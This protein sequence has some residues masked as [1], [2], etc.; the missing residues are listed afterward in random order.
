MGE[1]FRKQ[2]IRIGLGLGLLLLLLGHAAQRYEIPFVNQ[3]D[4]II[5]D[6][7]LRLTMPRTVDDRVVILDIDE[8][9][10]KEEGRWPWS[11]NRLALLLD[12]LFD[13]H[14]IAVLGFDIVFAERDESSGVQVL[15]QLGRTGLHDLPQ[16]RNAVAQ[17]APKLD[18]DRLFAE[19]MKGRRVV[20]GYY[21]SEEQG[22][23]VQVSGQLPPPV[24]PAGS[25]AGRPVAIVRFDGYGANLPELQKSAAGGGHFNPL[26]DPRDGVTRRVPMLGEHRGA[27]YEALSL[28]VV[29]ALLGFPPVVAGIA[30]DSEQY[31][32]L[33]WLDVPTERG[34][35]RIPVDSNACALVPYRGPEGSFR[36]LSASDVL[37]DRVEPGLLKGKIVLMGATAP[38]LLDLRSTPVQA[39]YPGVEIHA[40]LIAGMLDQNIKMQ[41]AYVMG[42]EVVFLLVSG[43]LLV[44][45]M[46][47]LS[48]FVS[49]LVTGSVLAVAV[50]S[51]VALWNYGGL[52]FPLASTVLLIV[53]LFAL[54]MS[55]GY[56]VEAR[57]KRLITG[58]FGRYVSPALVEEMATNPDTVSMEGDS[59]E[60]SV[61][62]SDVRGFTTISERMDPKE[63]SRFMNEFLTPLTEVI[64]QHRG[65]VDKY[66][67]DCIMAFWGAPLPDPNH[68]R[69]AVLAGMAM[70]ATLRGLQARFREMGW[71]EIRAGVGVNSGQVRVGNMGS[72]M[73]IAYTVM[74]DAVNLA[75]RLE[76]ITKQYGVDM[77]VGEHTRS[78]L[79]DF[80]FLELDRVRVKGKDEPVAIYQPLGEAAAAPAQAQEEARLF[81]QALRHY[82]NQDWDQAELALYNL[83]KISPDTELYRIYARRV[84]Y[85]RQHPPGARWDGVWV[86][87]T[88]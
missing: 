17:I 24:L 10:L 2:A 16:Y 33:E 25:F 84:A 20:L 22:K 14:Q 15:E 55:W 69:N 36:H 26:P 45:L 12:K 76:G 48:P 68:A 52:V 81:H 54:N 42:I 35:L 62:F 41:P 6:Y 56:F 72:Q 29:R 61:L 85:L 4:A 40:N 11:R 31:A 80:V 38:G 39:V 82:R 71:P 3:L 1:F 66:M 67:G 83:E 73:R 9:S 88:K 74:G 19:S 64:Y 50:A 63:L 57:S 79:P 53:G 49:A 30:G 43:L 23:Q 8:R 21:F 70:Q 87:E 27:Y 32:G 60:M 18:Y 75:S 44:F 7:R 78:A 77:V 46:P 86:F 59:R 47:V 13:Q 37:R 65:T 58:L 5:Y 34:V 51:N 28:A